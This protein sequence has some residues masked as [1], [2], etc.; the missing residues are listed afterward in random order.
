MIPNESETTNKQ[1]QKRKHSAAHRQPTRGHSYSIINIS[2]VPEC[3][4]VSESRAPGTTH[5]KASEEHDMVN[6]TSLREQHTAVAHNL[7]VYTMRS[8][9]GSSKSYGISVRPQTAA[10]KKNHIIIQ[11]YPRVPQTVGS[12]ITRASR[13]RDPRAKAYSPNNWNQLRGN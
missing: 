3:R 9:N 6:P 10:F 12:P 1:K 11:V 2:T 13:K 5:I 4:L 8:E 7:K